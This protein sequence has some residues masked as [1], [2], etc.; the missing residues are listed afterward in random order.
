MVA[1]LIK[2]HRLILATCFYIDTIELKISLY[3]ADKELE[4]TRAENNV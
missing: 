2:T 1:D 4:I 3:L